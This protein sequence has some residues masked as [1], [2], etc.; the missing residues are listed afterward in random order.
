MQQIVYFAVKIILLDEY[1][2]LI[3]CKISSPKYSFPE[4]IS[5]ARV[6]FLGFFYVRA[7]GR[8]T[9]TEQFFAC[10]LCRSLG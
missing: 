3:S 4:T 2:G 1:P 5:E 9:K 8:R 6:I 7:L 10:R